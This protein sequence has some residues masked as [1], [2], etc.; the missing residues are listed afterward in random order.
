VGYRI[1]P[2]V[3]FE[4][5]NWNM[6][7]SG[8][9]ISPEDNFSVIWT[10][11]LRVNSN[12]YY[13]FCAETDDGVRLWID[14]V[15]VINNWVDR[16]RTRDCTQPIHLDGGAINYFNIRMEYYDNSG[17]AIA[18][19]YWKE[20]PNQVC[21]SG[22][23]LIPSGVLYGSQSQAAIT[24]APPSGYTNLRCLDTTRL[25]AI[26]AQL[27]IGVGYTG[28]GYNRA[29]GLSFEEFV[30][31]QLVLP[32]NFTNFPSQIRRASTSG[33]IVSVRPDSVSEA[34]VVDADGDNPITYPNS[35]FIEVKAINSAIDLAY[36]NFQI[37]GMIDALAASDIAVEEPQYARPTLVLVTTCNPNSVISPDLIAEAARR[38]VL[39]YHAYVFE[40][41][42]TTTAQLMVGPYLLLNP[43][44]L[45]LL[46][47]SPWRPVIPYP[48][49][50]QPEPLVDDLTDPDLGE[51]A[52]EG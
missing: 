12:T 3:N 33:S 39:I 17:D 13:K 45:P 37:A 10:G 26:A 4:N 15:L 20:C 19:L 42:D 47:L 31:R 8:F 6:A 49:N 14:N 43:Q 5:N 1:D 27:G 21:P 36:R 48:S 11:Q 50:L 40:I 29:I 22:Q 41:G 51:E 23:D 25:Q 35:I 38:N 9:N 18:Q 34:I 32:R 52:V 28:I 30:L 2:Q 46:S 7:G 16:T 44:T 24:P